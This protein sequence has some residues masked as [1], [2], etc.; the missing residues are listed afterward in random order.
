[1]FECNN[2][3]N[4]RQGNSDQISFFFFFIVTWPGF[5]VIKHARELSWMMLPLHKNT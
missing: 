1:M 4:K 2:Q 3:C 5:L